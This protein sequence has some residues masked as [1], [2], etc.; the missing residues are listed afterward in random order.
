MKDIPILFTGEMVRAII[1]GQKKQTRRILKKQPPANV[2]SAGVISRSTE[3][4]TD[5]WTW[6]SGDPRDCD[7]WMVEDDFKTGYRPGDRLWV[8]ETW[9]CH[10]ANDAL[11][12]SEIESDLWTVRYFA[13]EHLRPA[14]RDGSLAL[15]SQCTK[16]R[17]AIFMPRWASRLTLTIEEVRVERL[18]DISLE[19][20][21]AEGCPYD[22][23][24]IDTTVDGSNPYMVAMAGP[25]QWQTPHL[26]YHRLWDSINGEG[27]WESNPWV[28]AITF[29]AEQ[30]NIDG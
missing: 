22:P 3:G 17:V 9:A 19:D 8:K 24:W 16:K 11:K 2:T 20:V 4:Q 27:A 10:Y 12:P 28:V 15:H 1:C 26:W 21:I 7:T 18:R 5:E 23:T 13:D 29:A 14:S 25:A 30:K 6:L